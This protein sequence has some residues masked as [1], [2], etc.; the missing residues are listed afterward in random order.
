MLRVS[1]G[2]APKRAR[3]MQQQQDGQEFGIA[4]AR[5]VLNDV[6]APRVKDRTRCKPSPTRHPLS[7]RDDH[8]SHDGNLGADHPPVIGATNYLA[9]W[10]V[11]VGRAPPQ[12]SYFS[13]GSGMR[14]NASL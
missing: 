8:Q 5:R 7:R 9:F 1:D 11:V 2:R 10:S 6:F 13:F 12:G 14:F 3:P 4:D